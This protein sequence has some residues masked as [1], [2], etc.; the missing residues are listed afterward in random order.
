M[1][2]IVKTYNRKKF[3]LKQEKEATCFQQMEK[4]I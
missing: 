2:Y 3:L 1:S 4:S